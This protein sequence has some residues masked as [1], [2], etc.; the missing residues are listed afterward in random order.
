M[1][2]TAHRFGDALQEHRAHFRV[3]TL[4]VFARE[5]QQTYGLIAR[6]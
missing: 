5:Y 4:L 3:K 2:R 1:Q 6:M